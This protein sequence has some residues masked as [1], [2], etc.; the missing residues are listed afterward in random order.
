MKFE[1]AAKGVKKIF[2]A[3]ILSLIAGIFTAVAT[4]LII[5]LAASA[6]L[7]SGA[8]LLASGFG[9][10]ALVTAAAVLIIIAFIFHI[11]GISNAAKDEPSFKTAIIFLIV[12]IVT[13]MVSAFTQAGVPVLSSILDVVSKIC[14][15]CVT[16]F[17]IQGVINLAEKLNNDEI[18]NKGRNLFKIITAMYVLMLIAYV[19]VAVFRAN[20]VTAT[21]AI[22]MVVIAMILSVIQYILFLVYLSSAKKM[23]NAE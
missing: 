10:V 8:G 22:V 6:K 2:S 1:N 23:L 21:I 5:P 17:I 20:P 14:S 4:I 7:E 19:L 9:M 12:G 3:E 15:L 16:L 18:A 11:I 13:S